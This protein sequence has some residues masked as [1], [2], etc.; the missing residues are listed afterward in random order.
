MTLTL[1]TIESITNGSNGYDGMAC[2]DATD[3]AIQIAAQAGTFVQS[4][5]GVTQHTG[6]DM[7][8]TVASGVL[9]VASTKYSP[10]S[11]TVAIGAASSTDRRDL[12]CYTVGTGY[13]CVA[14]TPCGIAGWTRN[15]AGFGPLKP[16]LPA[17]S[18]GV[19]EVYVGS[20]TTVITTALNCVDKTCLGTALQEAAN[21]SDVAD[22]GSS[23][24]NLSFPVQSAVAAVA[25]TNV[26]LSAPGATID[27]YS[28]L[29][30]DEVLL[31]GQTTSS[32]N[33]IWIW[34]GAASALTRPNEFVSGGVVKRGRTL[35]V[36]NG[37]VYA[38]SLWALYA[39]AAGLTIDTTAQVWTQSISPAVAPAAA[40]YM[41]A[42][43]R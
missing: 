30:N 37:A 25:V 14:G 11:A 23:R 24:F 33:G 3:W 35:M 5:C 17:N 13:Q 10:T 41:A 39:T 26:N 36:M 2:I 40:L 6:S 43:F 27:G 21:L 28:F 8:V 29:T 34:N 4:G 1:P 9:F 20:T 18:C 19:G 22:A 42:T 15:S 12:I 7:N 32:Q 16:A 38:G 31:T